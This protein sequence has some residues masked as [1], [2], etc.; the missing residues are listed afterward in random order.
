MRIDA[1]Q[2]I[3]VSERYQVL[4]P[5]DDDVLTAHPA[6][7]AQMCGGIDDS[8]PRE[9]TKKELQQPLT[10]KPSRQEQDDHDNDDQSQSSAWVISPRPAVRPRR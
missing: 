5:L 6:A 7:L 8:P 10:S 1:L 2:E 9:V 3:R 4:S